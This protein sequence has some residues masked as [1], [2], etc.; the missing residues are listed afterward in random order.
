VTLYGQG[1]HAVLFWDDG[2]QK[3]PTLSTTTTSP[4]ASALRA[5]RRLALAGQR[6]TSLR[7]SPRGPTLRS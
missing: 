5:M 4:R 1:N 6:A 2:H 7:S 3:I